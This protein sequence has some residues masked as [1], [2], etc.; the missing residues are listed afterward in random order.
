MTEYLEKTGGEVGKDGFLINSWHA[1]THPRCGTNIS[2][3]EDMFAWILLAHGNPRLTHLHVIGKEPPGEGSL[4][5]L[6]PTITFDGEA[7]WE[8]GRLVCTRD[9]AFR[10]RIARWG[11]PDELLQQVD[12]IGI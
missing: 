7:I 5:L 4:P 1:G 10:K 11:D 3:A 2:P 9:P 6:D 8:N 12:N